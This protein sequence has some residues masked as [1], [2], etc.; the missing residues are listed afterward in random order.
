MLSVEFGDFN[1]K[2]GK[3]DVIEFN[4]ISCKEDCDAMLNVL[5]NNKQKDTQI[6]FIHCDFKNIDF[7][8]FGDVFSDTKVSF[9]YSHFKNINM[10][11]KF[12]KEVEITSCSSAFNSEF[13]NIKIDGNHMSFH[14]CE[15]KNCDLSP[16]Y[17]GHFSN[18]TGALESK[19]SYNENLVTTVNYKKDSGREEIRVVVVN[20]ENRIKDYSIDS[21]L[22]KNRSVLLYEGELK[23]FFDANAEIFKGAVY[24]VIKN[25]DKNMIGNKDE[26]VNEQ[27]RRMENSIGNVKGMDKIDFFSASGGAMISDGKVAYRDS[28]L[29]IGIINNELMHMARF[30]L[31]DEKK[32]K[33]DNYSFYEIVSQKKSKSKNAVV[34]KNDDLER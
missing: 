7:D 16:V 26:I 21:L 18:C 29:E 17:L 34:T 1:E 27:F 6:D 15:F 19:L 4:S 9:K 24:N 8:N 11:D 5:K 30:E 33:K 31:E 14:D 32:V 28:F 22:K 2:T 10:S 20:D 25:F 23:D 3:A 12:A 13:N